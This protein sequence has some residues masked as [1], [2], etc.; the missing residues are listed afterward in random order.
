MKANKRIEAIASQLIANGKELV[1]SGALITTVGNTL[2]G[3]AETLLA[4]SSKANSLSIEPANDPVSYTGGKRGLAPVA[5]TSVTSFSKE[6]QAEL[7]KNG[8]VHTSD[9]RN[10]PKPK[11]RKEYA[12]VK[13]G[14][15]ELADFLNYPNLLSTT[16]NRGKNLKTNKV[17]A[18]KE[19]KVVSSSEK[20]GRKEVKLSDMTIFSKGLKKKFDSLGITTASELRAMPK[21]DLRDTFSGVKNGLTQLAEY[22]SY[23]SLLGSGQRGRKPLVSKHSIE[24][25]GLATNMFNKLNLAGFKFAEDIAN[26]KIGDL[27]NIKGI[28]QKRANQLQ[29]EASRIAS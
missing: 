11:L 20:R 15:A 5:I 6:L 24:E 19:K 16:D 17:T 23:P 18:K 13:N 21:S 27:T 1:G 4:Q 9:L 7:M 14:L 22:L 8:V 28:G 25:L 29:D 2:L 26:A 12:D 10:V 3:Q